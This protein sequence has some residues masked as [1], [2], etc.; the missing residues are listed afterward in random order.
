M[1]R[2]MSMGV[3][4]SEPRLLEELMAALLRNGCVTQRIGL[5]TF[6]A[7]HVQ[8]MHEAEARLELDFF[9]RAWSLGHP[10]VSVVRL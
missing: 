7:L 1:I 2:S 9:L 5:Q 8:A 3:S 10:D 6:V 4:I